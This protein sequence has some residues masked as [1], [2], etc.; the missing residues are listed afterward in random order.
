MR[1]PIGALA[2]LVLAALGTS[3]TAKDGRRIFVAVD[4]EG[5]AGRGSNEQLGPAGFE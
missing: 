4:M 3:A 5:I 2:A 1:S